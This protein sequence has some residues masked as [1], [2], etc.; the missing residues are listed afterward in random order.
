[1]SAGEQ[2]ELE[3]ALRTKLDPAGDKPPVVRYSI[4]PS[5]LG[6]MIIRI[7]DSLLDLSVSSMMKK[8][9]KS[10]QY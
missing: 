9:L 7:K 2:K 10:I 6:G 4:D 3:A 8:T 5:V 1:L